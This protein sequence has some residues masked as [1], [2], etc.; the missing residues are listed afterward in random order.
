MRAIVHLGMPKSGST[1]IQAFLNA[2]RTGLAAQG[3]AYDPARL[4][5]KGGI[6]HQTI[7]IAA[8][9]AA[10]KIMRAP[11][12]RREF[13][14]ADRAKQ[15]Q[16]VTQFEP[17]FAELLES[18]TEDVFVVSSEYLGA[19]ASSAE[20]A[21]GMHGWFMRY[22][23]RVDYVLYFRRQEDWIASSWSERLKR[24]RDMTLAELVDQHDSQNWNRVARI[25]TKAAGRD[26]VRVRLLEQDV[27]RDGDLLSDFC[28]VIGADIA[29]L[30]RISSRNEALTAPAAEILRALNAVEAHAEGDKLK[31]NPRKMHL[32]KLL[33]GVA[34]DWPPIGL[35]PDETA[36]VRKRYAKSNTR[37]CQEWF[38]D[39]S[40]LFPPRPPKGRTATREEVAEVA[41][42]LLRENAVPPVAVMETRNKAKGL[43]RAL[44]GR[45]K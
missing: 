28:D 4:D 38:P 17:R 35:S 2:N 5:G 14:L 41:A 30:D 40:E 29:Q 27:L 6:A 22:F 25:W 36:K 45:L 9:H 3:I 37:L 11:T 20:I 8:T 24:G 26:H 21:K 19:I 31:V 10:G 7:A 12:I 34:G 13:Q 43:A 44:S 16:V 23:D 39:R 32:R 33:Q 1:T 42:T 15:E 18:R